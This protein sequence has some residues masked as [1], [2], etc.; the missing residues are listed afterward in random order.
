VVRL[1]PLIVVTGEL[2][3]TDGV[4]NVIAHRLSALR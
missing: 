1:E 3:R 2:Q 4:V